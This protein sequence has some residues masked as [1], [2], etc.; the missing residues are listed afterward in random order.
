MN[1][2]GKYNSNQGEMQL[3]QTDNIVTGSYSL[4]GIIN[5]LIENNKLKAIWK[6]GNHEGLLEL[7]FNEDNSFAGK[8]KKGKE[9]GP[10]RIKWDGSKI[11]NNL[12]A[13]EPIFQN[14]ELNIKNETNDEIKNGYAKWHDNDNNVFDGT[15]ENNE[16]IDGKILYFDGG[17][18]EGKFRNCEL[19]GNGIR[20]YSDE[21]G[22]NITE[23]GNFDNGILIKGKI[24]HSNGF[25][26]EGN[27]NEEG[28]N[29]NGITKWPDGS[30][31]DGI[32][33]NSEFGE[34]IVRMNYENGIFFEGD[35]KGEEYHG[36]GNYVYNDDNGDLITENGS[37]ENG[38]FISGI[39]SSNKG[40]SMQG[41]FNENGLDG[42][43]L[44]KYNDGSFKDGLWKDGDFVEGKVKIFFDEGGSYEGGYKEDE[45][46][47]FGTLFYS[48]G[49]NMIGNWDS[50]EMIEGLVD[51]KYDDGST[52]IGQFANSKFNGQGKYTDMDSKIQE[53]F[54]IDGELTK[55]DNANSSDTY[56]GIKI[57]TS[58]K[59]ILLKDDVIYYGQSENGLP[60][61]K[62]YLIFPYEEIIEC[63]DFEESDFEDLKFVGIDNLYKEY[64][65]QFSDK[66]TVK[67]FFTAAIS[68][69]GEIYFNDGLVYKGSFSA[70]SWPPIMQGY[71]EVFDQENNILFKGDFSDGVLKNESN[72]VLFE[73]KIMEAPKYVEHK[74][75]DS[76]YV[77]KEANGKPNGQGKMNYANGTYYE[78]IWKDC[79]LIDGFAKI[80]FS[81]GQIF[82]GEF[83]AGNYNGKGKNIMANGQVFEGY[84]KDGEYLSGRYTWP[85][86]CIWEG[87]FIDGIFGGSGKLISPTNG[88]FVGELYNG[89][90]SG[91]GRQDYP[92]KDYMVG[93]WELGELKDG[94]VRL[95]NMLGYRY[96]GDYKNG[97]RDGNG[98]LFDPKNDLIKDGFFK[99]GV[100]VSGFSKLTLNDGT[101]L[102]GNTE[103]GQ[104]R[105]EYPNNDF[106]DGL[107]KDHMFFEGIVRLTNTSG[108]VY[109]GSYMKGKRHGNGK[110]INPTGII[111]YEGIFKHGETLTD[112]ETKAKLLEDYATKNGFRIKPNTLSGM[113][114]IKSIDYEN[115]N[116]FKDT[117]IEK[118]TAGKT[119]DALQ[120]FI[121]YYL[122]HLPPLDENE[123]EFVSLLEAMNKNN[124]FK[125]PVTIIADILDDG[126]VKKVRE[127]N[128]EKIYECVNSVFSKFRIV[129]NNN[130]KDYFGSQNFNMD[131]P[132]SDDNENLFRKTKRILYSYLTAG[133]EDD[134]KNK[135]VEFIINLIEGTEDQWKSWT[136]YRKNRILSHE[137]NISKA[138]VIKSKSIVKVMPKKAEI[139]GV[140]KVN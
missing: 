130:G 39:S 42:E 37:W 12:N 46:N 3:E 17:I 74:F 43:G 71:G 33:I 38:V 132:I 41:H 14:L 103:N 122:K 92:N 22:I 77:G 61:G 96:E 64:K 101:K 124:E 28:L 111:I 138:S 4:K 115:P 31:Q 6:N 73:R 20:K 25:Y 29:G 54:W 139:K 88:I 67:A 95:T 136:E 65:Y 18:E 7:E 78:G 55:S 126:S 100:F 91:Y 110:L 131:I 90:K 62:G 113:F 120:Y 135:K 24:T 32:W 119:K 81:S 127:I 82:E 116:Y 47:G 16:F 128:Y 72:E 89:L 123:N 86:G 5:G 60:I 93:F 53:G 36:S 87:G 134:E 40:I 58:L 98:K 15:W 9:D 56:L 102:T 45:Y 105:I 30:F 75:D 11:E 66:N 117:I 104:G 44:K 83:K 51:I 107:W 52:Y 8:Y 79:I 85:D 129:K 63:D 125:E 112:L 35:M 1:I 97:E 34:G 114:S 118:L 70:I 84:F 137:N 133:I 21:E 26:E 59:K 68:S 10:M 27:F 106:E 108:Y 48:D 121:Y 23:E 69:E 76:T 50:G 2:S 109:E 80:I 140:K 57:D 49:S 94:K 13:N 19:Y 99:N